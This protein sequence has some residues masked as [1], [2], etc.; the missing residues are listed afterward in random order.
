MTE[1]PAM[2]IPP[3]FLV[4][5]HRIT[6][7]PDHPIASETRLRH[8]QA[9]PKLQVS[10]NCHHGPVGVESISSLTVMNWLPF[11]PVPAIVITAVLVGTKFEVEICRPKAPGAFPVGKIFVSTPLSLAPA[12]NVIAGMVPPGGALTLTLKNAPSPPL[13]C[14]TS[15]DAERKKPAAAFPGT[16]V[17]GIVVRLRPLASTPLIVKL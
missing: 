13:I 17:N 5:D 15:G 10:M 2:P 1:L 6:R 11:G 16:T 9:P 12:P 3:G 7:S 4:S 8:G 14:S